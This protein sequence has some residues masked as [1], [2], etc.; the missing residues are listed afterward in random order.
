MNDCITCG[1]GIRMRSQ[2]V[3]FNR[4]RGCA[5]WLETAEGEQCICLKSFCWTK[6][7]SD[8]SKPSVT[9]KKIAEWN[10]ANDAIGAV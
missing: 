2:R 6:W 5:H 8:K 3:S 10:A 1:R 4:K 9:D 7:L